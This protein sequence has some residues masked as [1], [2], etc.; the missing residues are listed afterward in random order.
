MK[1]LQVG[2]LAETKKIAWLGHC[3]AALAHSPATA[4]V[5]SAT[6]SPK[7]L[8]WIATLCPGPSFARRLP[9]LIRI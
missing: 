3:I 4:L 9:V 6:A 2:S 7:L 5:S 8:R 1:Y